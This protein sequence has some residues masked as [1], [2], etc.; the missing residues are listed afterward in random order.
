M[1]TPW[2]A[3]RHGAAMSLCDADE[4]G[5]VLTGSVRKNTMSRIEKMEAINPVWIVRRTSCMQFGYV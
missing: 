4:E 5:K 2:Y 3:T 1:L